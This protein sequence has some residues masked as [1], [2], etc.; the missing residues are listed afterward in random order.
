MGFDY[1]SLGSAFDIKDS[2]APC[3]GTYRHDDPGKE[4]ALDL[5]GRKHVKRSDHADGVYWL[6]QYTRSSLVVFPVP[7]AASANTFRKFLERHLPYNLITD[8]YG[9]VMPLEQL[10]D[11]HLPILQVQLWQN[12]TNDDAN[13]A[14]QAGAL[15]RLVKKCGPSA[16]HRST[17]MLE[18]TSEDLATE[19]IR[20]AARYVRSIVDLLKC[21]SADYYLRSC[22]DRVSKSHLYPSQGC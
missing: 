20:A 8:E 6:Q 21:E 14:S 9:H 18:P 4:I 16:Q 7:G 13:T 2:C 11:D 3:H 19:Q 10:S 22:T 15:G 17:T 1:D 12:R 5:Q